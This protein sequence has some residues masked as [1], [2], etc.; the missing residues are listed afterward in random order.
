MSIAPLV[1]AL[2]IAPLVPALV[3][4]AAAAP[5]LEE[6]QKAPQFQKAGL[7]G[8]QVSLAAYRGKVVYLDFWASW[9]APCAEALPALERLRHEFPA[10]DFQVVAVNVDHDPAAARIFLDRRP[11]GYPSAFDP[12]GELPGRFGVR[13][14]PTSFLIDR[15][16]VV[17][18]VHEGFR[19]GDVDDLRGRIQAL[20]A[21]GR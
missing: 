18:H 4:L 17:R 15:K 5:A 9:C 19:K 2:R 21:T 10:S 6:G 12:D 1:R 7:D 14:M 3:G 8:G 20:V 16:G 13:T 11:V